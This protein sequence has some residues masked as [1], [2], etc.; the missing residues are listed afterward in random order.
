M[1]I[2]VIKSN[3]WKGKFYMNYILNLIDQQGKRFSAVSH[4]Q[5]FGDA[6]ASSVGDAASP[7]GDAATRVGDVH[8]PA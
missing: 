1:H 3:E 2:Q 5:D 7:A 4:I 8:L 6:A